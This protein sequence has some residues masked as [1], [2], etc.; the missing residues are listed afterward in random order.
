M[1]YKET[2]HGGNFDF[3]WTDKDI[4]DLQER[5]KNDPVRKDI[6]DYYNRKDKNQYKEKPNREVHEEYKKEF[7]GPRE[8]IPEHY[9][10]KS[11]KEIKISFKGVILIVIISALVLSTLAYFFLPIEKQQALNQILKENKTNVN[12]IQK[13]YLNNLSEQQL[14]KARVLTQ[15]AQIKEFG[16]ILVEYKTELKSENKY[17]IDIPNKQK[18]NFIDWIKTFFKK[19]IINNFKNGINCTDGTLSYDCS[20]NKPYYCNNGTLEKKPVK[21]GCPEDYKEKNDECVKIQRCS[22][23]TPYGECSKQRPYL[24]NVGNLVKDEDLCMCGQ[25]Y[26]YSKGHCIKNGGVESSSSSDD[27]SLSSMGS[28]FEITTIDDD[29]VHNFMAIVNSERAKQGIPA[30]Q[31]SSQLNSIAKSRFNKMMEQPFISHYG[32]EAY[33]VGEVIF[34]SKG[35][36]EKDY[37]ENLQA[38]AP[39]HWD[40][41]M[42]PMVSN[43]GYHI[44]EGP[45]MAVYDPCSTTEIPGPNIDV[46]EFFEQNGCTTS[47]RNSIWLVIDMT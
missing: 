44:E 37:I 39:L 43:Y 32:A 31:E 7:I 23:G 41:L 38:T 27:S 30:M 11:K 5:T 4:K 29:W 46:K 26:Y 13:I 35:F 12:Y 34:Y 18:F 14:K 10:N 42:N 28:L 45:T 20:D 19:I 3:E 16:G 1:S 9:T 21:C 6:R 25:N 22:D 33:N 24:C 2:I 36:S 47:I 40:G 17:D 8:Q 15:E